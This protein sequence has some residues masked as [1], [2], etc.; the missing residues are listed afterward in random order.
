VIRLIAAMDAARGIA[1]EN[2]I[3]WQ[4]RLPTDARY[5]QDQT[6]EGTIVMGYGT[7]AEF[8]GPL[9]DRVNYVVAREGTALRPGFEAVADL[10]GFFA[11]RSGQV[12]WV[13][14]G[15]GL[16]AQSVASADELYITQ[17][18]GTFG[19]TKFFPAFADEFTEASSGPPQVENDIAFRF[20]IWRRGT[21][22]PEA[23]PATSDA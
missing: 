22:G 2:G 1:G 20:Q 16:Y 3:P 13:V 17:L 10:D 7:Y 9:H 4:G 21:D 6:A 18:E 19:C 11:D 15:A 8:S 5:F 12:V 14:G 23:W